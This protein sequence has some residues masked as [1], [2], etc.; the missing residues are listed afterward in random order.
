MYTGNYLQLHFRFHSER[1]SRD[2]LIYCGSRNFIGY[3]NSLDS[4]D[5]LKYY[6]VCFQRK[7]VVFY[8]LELKEN[9]LINK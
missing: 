8:W 4:T 7:I 9:L 3:E 5:N 1:K 6:L 2:S